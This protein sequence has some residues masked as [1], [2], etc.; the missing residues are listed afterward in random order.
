MG[1]KA[2]LIVLDRNLFEIPTEELPRVKVVATMMDGRVVHEEAIDW[3]PPQPIRFS[4]CGAHDPSTHFD[5]A[6]SP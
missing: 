1:K 4:C 3:D 5:A 6:S 2:D